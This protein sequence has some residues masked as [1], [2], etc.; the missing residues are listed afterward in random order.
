[1]REIERQVYFRQ[2]KYQKKDSQLSS[3][4]QNKCIWKAFGVKYNFDLFITS[5]FSTHRRLPTQWDWNF[6]KIVFYQSNT[7]KKIFPW[8]LVQLNIFKDYCKDFI[9]LHNISIKVNLKK[10]SGLPEHVYILLQ[11][12]SHLRTWKPP[13]KDSKQGQR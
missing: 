3:N 8:S 6:N 9:K 13:R 10:N 1:M 12:S 4:L 7:L 11:A 5:L 2:T